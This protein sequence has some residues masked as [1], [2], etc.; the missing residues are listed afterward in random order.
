MPASHEALAIHY[1]KLWGCAGTWE[2]PPPIT[3]ALQIGPDLL[4]NAIHHTSPGAQLCDGVK[5]SVIVVDDNF[6]G[7]RAAR[8]RPEGA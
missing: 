2:P 7:L 1:A 8:V 3:S 6:A 4:N 5:D